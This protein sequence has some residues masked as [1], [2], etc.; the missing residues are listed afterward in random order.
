M[1]RCR[2]ILYLLLAVCPFATP[3][4]ALS[5]KC[6]TESLPLTP[7]SP[8]SF[9]H[10]SSTLT[11]TAKATLRRAALIVLACDSCKLCLV[12]THPWSCSPDQSATDWDRA[13]RTARFLSGPLHVLSSR[14]LFTF[15]EQGKSDQLILDLGSKSDWPDT[16]SAHP[17]LHHPTTVTVYFNLNQYCLT[18]ESDSTLDRYFQDAKRLGRTQHLEIAGYCDNSGS[19]D[20]NNELSLKRAG[21][22]KAYLRQLRLDSSPEMHITAHGFHEPLNE[23]QTPADRAH[24][25]R[26][27]IAAIPATAGPT[28]P[29]EPP[30]SVYKQLTDTTIR[31]GASIVL[32]DVVFIGG[33]H[34]PLGFSYIA[35]ND[36]LKAM[37]ENTAL[38][39]RIEGHV[40]CIPD[41]VDGPDLETGGSDLSVQRAK[42]VYAFLVGNGIARVRMSYLGLG[43]ANKL[44]P[45]EISPAQQAQN[46]RVEIRIIAK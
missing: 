14:I 46:R 4:N 12:M 43:G 32:K 13:T 29:S 41:S 24:N 5:L 23:N 39:I 42:F 16:P 28:A 18:R 26:V 10:N 33:R 25:R 27:T 8:I 35:L 17:G 6:T 20:Y 1:F 22:V 7:L 44:Y 11:P 36:L 37:R 45:Q 3:A 31:A 15:T 34:Q 9:Q 21:A 19:E 30:A 38:R 40:C 2:T